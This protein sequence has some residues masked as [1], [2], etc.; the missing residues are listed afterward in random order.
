MVWTFPSRP[1]QQAST[2]N[3]SRDK[4]VDDAEAHDVFS[5]Q[6]GNGQGW[7]GPERLNEVGPG[8]TPR[9]GHARQTG[10]HTQCR[11]CREHNRSLNG[12]VPAARRHEHVQ[13]CRTEEG[14]QRIGLWRGDGHT[15]IADHFAQAYSRSTHSRDDAHDARIEGELQQDA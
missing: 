8:I 3:Q 15:G 10:S 12:P 6:F 11:A 4:Q 14:K 7:Q 5:I 2:D 13:D 9:D 1:K